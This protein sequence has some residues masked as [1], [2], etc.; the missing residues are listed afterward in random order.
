[1]VSTSETGFPFIRLFI[2]S[3][4]EA[5]KVLEEYLRRH[6]PA[7]MIPKETITVGIFPLNSNGKIDRKVLANRYSQRSTGV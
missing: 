3:E 5:T 2:E 4:E 6:L 1:M 7:Y